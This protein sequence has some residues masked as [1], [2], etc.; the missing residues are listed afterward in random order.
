MVSKQIKIVNKT[1]LH[2]RPASEFVALSAKFS[3]KIE[4]QRVGEEDL[5]N[6]KSIIMLLALGLEQGEEAI[7]F[8]DGEDEAAALEELSALVAS[9]T[10]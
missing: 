5:Y 7:L 9:F 4:L 2:A 6:G 1:G 3:A 10:E 8:A